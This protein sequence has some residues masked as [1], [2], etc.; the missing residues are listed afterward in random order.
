VRFPF[1][2]MHYHFVALGIRRQ[3]ASIGEATSCNVVIR[4]GSSWLKRPRPKATPADGRTGRS[5][6]D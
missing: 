1:V 4:P 6:Q 5:D 3:V 2:N